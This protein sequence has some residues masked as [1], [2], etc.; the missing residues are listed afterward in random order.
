MGT[1]RY[2]RPQ[3]GDTF[4]RWTVTGHEPYRKEVAARVRCA[5]GVERV[6]P[7]YNLR[8]GTS[9]ACRWCSNGDTHKVLRDRTGLADVIPDTRIRERWLNRRLAAIS[10]C[11]NPANRKY[12]DYG[13]RGVY[14]CQEWLEDPAAFLRWVVGQPGWQDASLEIDRAD[15]DGPYAPGN[16]RLAARGQQCANTRV[17]HR[18]RWQGRD[19]SGTDF[20]REF[21][22]R[23]RSPG[24]V[25]RKL[26]E[27][28]HP[29]QIIAA[30]AGCRGPYVRHRQ[31]RSA[32]P[33]CD[34][35]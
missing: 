31:L 17:A 23:Y 20:W 13:G 16:C 14:V 15:N 29:E 24:I 35:D 33:V 6:V 3:V 30:Q 1:S 9:T 12:K 5:C 8:R 32:E 25:L 28:Q 10:R 27:G 2:G 21:C 7:F 11:H 22:P 26:R 18:V 19:L 34:S 4:G